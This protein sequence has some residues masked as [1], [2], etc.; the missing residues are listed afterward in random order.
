M[1]KL[2]AAPVKVREPSPLQEAHRSA[3][4]TAVTVHRLELVAVSPSA[5][6]LRVELAGAEHL[7][8]TVALIAENGGGRPRPDPPPTPPPARGGRHAALRLPPGPPPGP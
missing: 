7:P 5:A 8:S 1:P 4:P 2:R 3:M 6:L